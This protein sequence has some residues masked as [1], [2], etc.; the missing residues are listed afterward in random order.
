MKK[1]LGKFFTNPIVASVLGGAILY[2]LAAIWQAMKNRIDIGRS[3]I[4]LAKKIYHINIPQFYLIVLI[5]ILVAGCLALNNKIKTKQKIINDEELVI[6]N[7][8]SRILEVLAESSS[9]GEDE[10][11]L[12]RIY[13]KIFSG[14]TRKHYKIVL[15]DLYDE[16]LISIS[17]DIY[18]QNICNITGEGLSLLKNILNKD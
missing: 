10:E 14:K 7:E 4:S 3:F 18:E 15:H 16:G 5:L 17:P 8:H 1:P 11:E 2:I 9:G 13:L 6:T 12:F